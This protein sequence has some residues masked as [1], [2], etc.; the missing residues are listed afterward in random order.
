MIKKFFLFK[1]A[2]SSNN[3]KLQ[4]LVDEANSLLI[5]IHDKHGEGAHIES[6]NAVFQ[7]DLITYKDGIVTISYGTGFN[8]QKDRD[9]EVF[10]VAYDSEKD[11]IYSLKSWIKLFKENLFNVSEEGKNKFYNKIK[12]LVEQLNIL[13]NI[14]YDE[15]GYKIGICDTSSSWQEEEDYV[16]IV[17]NF[18]KNLIFK[19]SLRNENN[20]LQNFST[21]NFEDLIK[22]LEELIKQYRKFIKKQ[23][24]YPLNP[25]DVNNL[26][27]LI[28]ILDNDINKKF[29]KKVNIEGVN[30]FFIN[31]VPYKNK[32]D[33]GLNKY[34][35]IPGIYMIQEKENIKI[36]ISY[37]NEVYFVHEQYLS[38]IYKIYQS[39]KN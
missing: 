22:E 35:I 32:L 5:Q 37:Y 13:I 17:Y 34:N 33:D 7:V 12:D 29:F 20:D 4:K 11:I 2:V 18:G 9:K 26:Q 19:S 21:R 16:P 14:A 30:P 10:E 1:E 3:P 39:I 27:K 28:E 31:K 15:Y 23:G 36:Y 25:K 24:V 38:R 6:E 8:Y